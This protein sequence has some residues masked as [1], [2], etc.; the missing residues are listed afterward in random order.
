MIVLNW[1]IHKNHHHTSPFIFSPFR[2]TSEGLLPVV[3]VP[4]VSQSHER[5]EQVQFTWLVSVKMFLSYKE[6]W[7]RELMKQ[8]E[9]VLS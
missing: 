8:K 4:I 2:K 7:T 6:P 3:G 1:H 5:T 9:C